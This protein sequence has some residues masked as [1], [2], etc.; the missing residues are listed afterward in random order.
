MA[1]AL[2]RSTGQKVVYRY[3]PA[4]EVQT[5]MLEPFAGI[6][7]EGFAFYD[8]YSYFGLGAEE[9]VVWA[10]ETARGEKLTTLDEFFEAPISVGRMQF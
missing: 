3:A 2:S 9:L 5:G 6:F 8:E 10:V 4:E 7:L 1:A